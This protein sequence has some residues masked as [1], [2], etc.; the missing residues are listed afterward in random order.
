MPFTTKKKNGTYKKEGQKQPK[1]KILKARL[2][3]H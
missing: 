2:K 1:L 3:Y